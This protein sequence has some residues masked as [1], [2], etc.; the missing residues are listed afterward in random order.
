MDRPD[1]AP[2][3]RLATPVRALR[4]VDPRAAELLPRIGLKTAAD[5]VFNF[6]RDYLDL[7]DI[8]AIRDLEHGQMAGVVGAVEEIDHRLTSNGGSVTGVLIRDETDCL[9]AIWFNQGF[10]R[11]KFKPGQRV[12][13]SGKVKREGL[14]WEMA[15]PKVRYLQ[16]DQQPKGQIVP[17]YR[18]CEGLRQLDV[19]RA[20]KSA[21]QLAHGLEEAF[22]ADYLAKKR[23]LPIDQA[24]RLVH[25]P[26][27]Q[28]QLADARRRFVY[29]ELFVLQLALALRR[30]TQQESLAAEMPATALVDS[31]I[32]R[33]FPFELTAGQNAAIGEVAADMA[34]PKPMNRLLQGDV[35]CGKTVV[36]V[37]AMLLAVAHGYQ[38]ALMAPTE[39]LAHQHAQTLRNLLAHSQV[40]LLELTGAL[41]PRER[42]DAMAA[43]AAGQVD[44]VVGTQALIQE[45]V[46]FAKLGLVVIDEQHKFGVRQRATLKQAGM[47]PHYLVMT[48]TPIPRSV[49]MTLFGDLDIS[50]IRDLPPGRQKVNTYLTNDDL[51][52]RWWEFFRKKL[53]AGQQGYVITPRVEEHETLASAEQHFQE[54][55]AG[56]LAGFRLGLLHGRMGPDE[57]DEQMECFRTGQTQ[58][59]VATTVVEVG[60]DVPRATLMAIE[61][62]ER[63][64]LSQL[65]QLRGRISRGTEPGYCA[66]FCRPE[67]DDARKRLE[68][69]ASST[70]GFELAEVD[71]ELRG[72]GDLLGTRQHGLA[73]LR[74]ADLTRDQELLK[75]ARADAQQ[76]VAEDPHLART[77]HALLKA[78]LLR[79]YGKTLDLGDVG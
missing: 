64:G 75:L 67:N 22:P 27:T 33:L 57:K 6:P 66:V 42:Q 35:G 62:G 41:T 68:A 4:G 39:V 38:S 13:V 54:L 44:V 43:I 77:E 9:R 19:R 46:A 1:D 53:T 52:A 18:L 31:R 78:Q 48:A 23:L 3:K 61:D 36:A 24:I 26:E 55:A 50:F 29:Q 72:P 37:Y 79:R 20:V 16:E 12:L 2:E 74:I 70:D 63:F 8:R 34:R 7:T 11:D 73:R 32:R 76:L 40:R 25:F 21:L 69:L 17:V 49:T 47:C 65:H 71:F 28:E 10:M 59:L 58:V 14:V 15:H 5:L 45:D 51:R 60:V 56:E 30:Q